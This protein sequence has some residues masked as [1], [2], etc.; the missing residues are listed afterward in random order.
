M[1]ID[2]RNV[3]DILCQ[4]QCR[5]TQ[6]D[7]EAYYPFGHLDLRLP[8]TPCRLV[9]HPCDQCLATNL[10]VRTFCCTWTRWKNPKVVTSRCHKTYTIWNSPINN[11]AGPRCWGKNAHLGRE[12]NFEL[13]NPISFVWKIGRNLS[14]NR[15]LLWERKE[16]D[17]SWS[18][19]KSRPF[20]RS[21]GLGKPVT[22]VYSIK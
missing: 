20:L 1:N 13:L 5:N 22:L 15:L 12:S 9:D 21:S 10:S 4:G 6:W 11:R 17:R 18:S 16:L 2:A 14:E 19:I 8:K 7:E 3:V